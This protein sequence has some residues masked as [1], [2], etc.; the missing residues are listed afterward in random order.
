MDEREPMTM[1][2]SGRPVG[3][4][5]LDALERDTGRLMPLPFRSFLLRHNGGRPRPDAFTVVVDGGLRQVPAH[6][7]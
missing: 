3:A 2:G 7:W 5:D 4:A 1:R 6:D